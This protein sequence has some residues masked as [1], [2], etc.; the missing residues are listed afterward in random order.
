MINFFRAPLTN[1]VLCLLTSIASAEEWNVGF[2]MIPIPDS[3]FESKFAVWYPTEVEP[4]SE[5]FGIATLQIAKNAKPINTIR[6]LIIISHGFSGNF[7]SHNDTAQ[8]LAKFGYVVATP[9]HP[10]LHGL[11]SGK[12]EFDPLVT[13]PRYIQSII[14]KL[15]NHPLFKSNALQNRVGIVGFSLGAY[16]ALVATGVVPD[17]SNLATYCAIK[18]EDELL[19]SPEATRRL[20]AIEP[21]LAHQPDYQVKAAVLLAPAY[22]PLFSDKSFIN[23]TIPIKIVSAEEDKALDNAYNAQY[24]KKLLPTKASHEIVKRAG[25]FVF[26]APCSIELKQAAPVICNDN[27]FVDRTEIHQKLNRDIVNFFKSVF[28]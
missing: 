12:P 27:K 19:C 20:T 22:G 2:R 28:E 14:N 13:R 7:L 17:L 4:I 11:R 9:T 15:S 1:F 21:Y 6:G 24:F 16:S 10:D 18:T 25:H 8:T 5:T 3:A 23:V 26:M